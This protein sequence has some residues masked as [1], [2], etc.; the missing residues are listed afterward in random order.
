MR[1][2]VIVVVFVALLFF[3]LALAVGCA[4]RPP[5]IVTEE[6][7]VFSRQGSLQSEVKRATIESPARVET[8]PFVETSRDGIKVTGAKGDNQPSAA[9]I[10]AGRDWVWTLVCGIPAVLLIAWSAWLFHRGGWKTASLYPAAF[11]VALLIFTITLQQFAW[12]YTALIVG[13]AVV[14]AVALFLHLRYAYYK[15]L[16]DKDGS[17]QSAHG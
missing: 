7:R 17:A 4:S 15:G 1:D 13:A 16:S 10:P 3:L 9:A 8:A 2:L 5:R 12:I 14:G 11:G 6:R